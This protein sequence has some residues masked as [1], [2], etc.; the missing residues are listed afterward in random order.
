MGKMLV[1]RGIVLLKR[2]GKLFQVIAAKGV[3]NSVVGQTIEV[4]HPLRSIQLTNKLIRGNQ[5][6]REFLN[7]NQQSLIIPILSQGRIVG[8]ITLG[9]RLTKS[10]FSALDKKIIHSLVNLIRC[11]D[12]EGTH[13]RSSERSKSKPR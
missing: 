10:P 3:D 7:R 11:S 12:R 9:E 2:N 8:Y 13:H 4:E 1:T 5:Q 6:W